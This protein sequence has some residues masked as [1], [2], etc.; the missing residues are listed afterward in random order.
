[1]FFRKRHNRYFYLEILGFYYFVLGCAFLTIGSSLFFSLYSKAD[2]LLANKKALE[3]LFLTSS[4]ECLDNCTS[5]C[6]TAVSDIYGTWGNESYY[7][8]CY[9]LVGGLAMIFGSV[10]ML[11]GFSCLFATQR[12]KIDGHDYID[13]YYGNNENNQDENTNDDEDESNQDEK[14][15]L[16]KNVGGK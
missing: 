13:D 7:N 15:P 3:K 8:K 14:K 10:I 2:T 9:S 11:L 4:G 1:M 12:V 5:S 6:A 16:L